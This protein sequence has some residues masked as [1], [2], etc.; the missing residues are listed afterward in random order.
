MDCIDYELENGDVCEIVKKREF[1][2]EKGKLVIEPLGI[3]VLEFLDK[4]FS[5][6]FQYDYTR[7]MENALDEIACGKEG[8]QWK[9]LCKSCL[10]EI[11]GLIETVEKTTENKKMEYIIDENHSY[12]IGRYGPVIKCT[13]GKNISF[14]GLRKDLDIDL[15]RLAKGEYSLDELVEKAGDRS[16]SVKKKWEEVSDSYNTNNWEYQGMPLFVKK[17]KFGI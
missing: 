3:L 15:N 10:Q 6:L 5:N 7:N 4:H 12:I 11:N 2:N 16:G 13:I 14:K 17:G 1:G 8:I 9:D